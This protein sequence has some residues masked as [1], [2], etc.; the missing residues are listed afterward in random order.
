MDKGVATPI[1]VIMNQVLYDRT[2]EEVWRQAT[3]ATTVPSAVFV[4]LTADAHEGK[5][6]PIG[7]VLGTK[8]MIAPSAAGYDINCGML[9]LTTGIKWEKIMAKET[10]RAIM[11]AIQNRVAFGTGRHRAKGQMDLTEKKMREILQYG[12][13]PLGVSKKFASLKFERPFFPVPNYVEYKQAF[14]LSYGQLGS[15]GGGNH[16][17]EL[18]VDQNDNV[19]IMIHTG[20]RRYGHQVATEFFNEG[21]VWWNERHHDQ[22][23][24]G[25]KEMIYFPHDSDIGRRYLNAMHQAANFALANRYMIAVATMDAFEEVLH[26]HAEIYCELSHNIVA[27]EEGLWVHRKGATR[28][29]PAGHPM[30]PEE[31][32]DRGQRVLIP[33][34]MGSS[35]AILEALPGSIKTLYSVNHGA[36]RNMGR[37]EAN[38]TLNQLAANAEMNEKDILFNGRDVPLDE[39]RECYKDIDEVLRT[40]EGAGLAKIQ[41]ILRPVAVLKGTD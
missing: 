11:E 18:Q 30:L 15:L 35:S 38:R 1:H 25:D 5:G 34:S 22:L 8:D 2:K 10:R 7:L 20:S 6:V 27:Q 32:R 16:F 36:G 24:N 33:G 4:G 37:G 39:S 29:L 28:A 40:V 3:W 19:G 23:R 9:Y 14:D 17:W 21:R 41:T 26:E 12:L 13:E 31:L